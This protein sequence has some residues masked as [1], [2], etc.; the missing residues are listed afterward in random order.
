MKRRRNPA[1]RG[2]RAGL[3]CATRAGPRC[4]SGRGGSRS[5]QIAAPAN[6]RLTTLR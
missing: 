5:K 6:F 1:E 2:R 4:S 3:S